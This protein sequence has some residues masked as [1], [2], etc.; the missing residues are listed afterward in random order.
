MPHYYCTK[1]VYVYDALNRLTQ[2][3]YNDGTPA[4]S[5][6]YDYVP[7][8]GIGRLTSETNGSSTNWLNYD[9]LGRV[10][11]SIQQTNG[12]ASYSISYTYDRA[13]SLVSE[14][15]PSGRVVT[16]GYDTGERIS[17]VA[18]VLNGVKTNYVAAIGYAPHSGINSI[19]LGNGMFETFGYNSRLQTSSLTATYNNSPA[20]TYLQHLF[21]W[22]SSNN[23]GTL[24]TAT[25]QNGGPGYPGFLTFQQS[26][27]Y[28]SFNRL[29][30]VSDTGYS[31]SFG[32]DQYGNRW[33]SADSGTVGMTGVDANRQYLRCKH[34]P[35]A[36]LVV[37]SSRKLDR[38]FRQDADL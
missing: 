33:V 14:T 2:K 17:S 8:N 36:R 30:S 25:E 13:G 15:Y 21:D 10:A 23:N 18:G 28:D 24:R 26:Y 7:A 27:N 35:A 11:S 12:G 20:N 22:G 4:V 38:L 6:Y 16:T 29:S 34:E 9:T 1:T 3:T 19:A 5:Y 32:Y 37:R 31:R